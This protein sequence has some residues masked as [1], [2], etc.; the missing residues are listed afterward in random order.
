M[1]PSKPGS[2]ARLTFYTTCALVLVATNAVAQH[3][4]PMMLDPARLAHHVERFNAADE[5]DV[6]NLV[7]NSE[8]WD[9][10]VAQAPLWEC[11]AGQF[12][13]IYYFRWWT[14]RKHIKQTPAGRVLTE[15]ILP[16]SHA[17]PHNTVACAVGHHLAEGRWLWDQSLLDDYLMF[18]FRGGDH[19]GR[20]AHF[21]NFSSWVPAALYQRALATG[22]RALVRVLVDDLAADYQAWVAERGTEDGLFWQYD[23]RDG[24]EESISGSRRERHIRPTI[25]SYMAANAAAIS[26]IAHWAGQTE[27]AAEYA[28]K[29]GDLR[30]RMIDALW[31]E[32]AQFFKVRRADGAISDA[33]EAIGYIP[34]M[35]ELAR[36][37]HAS[38]W[39]QIRD[40]QGFWAPWGLTTAERRHPAFRT[41]GTGTCE[42]DGAI[43]PFATSQTLTGLANLLRGPEQRF[44]SRRDFFEL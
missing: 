7:P 15:F 10:I 31:D 35:F 33:R 30:K 1:I 23:V 32:E 4:G 3:S 40:P 16:V 22:D 8:A 9:W 43:W 6:V 37:Q 39:A 24:M 26:R 18:W 27:L 12:E 44:V 13:E 41:H 17:G 20:A 21:H 38:A 36:P 34:W 11:P 28:A 5:E 14:Y 19:G 29:A 42:W 25:N 2:D